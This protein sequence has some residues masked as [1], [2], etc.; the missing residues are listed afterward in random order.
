MKKLNSTH[1]SF[2]QAVSASSLVFG[3]NFRYTGRGIYT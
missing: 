3:G 2:T 1:H